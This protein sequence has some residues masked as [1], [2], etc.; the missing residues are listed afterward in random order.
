MGFVQTHFMA[1]GM[2]AGFGDMLLSGMMGAMGGMSVLGSITLGTRSDRAGRRGPLALAYLLRGLGFV[3]L[4]GGGM[5]GSIPLLVLSVAALGFSWAATISLTTASC[6]DV[7]GTKAAGAIVGVA[8]FIMWVGNAAG[9]YVPAL[10]AAW[11]G[12]YAP[13]LWLN[14]ALGVVAAAVVLSIGEV[15]LV[16]PRLAESR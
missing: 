15:R 2:G 3:A 8:L 14:T 12:S 1:Y 9:A 7:W 6:A 13:S 4:A 5:V 11:T 10:F 16:A